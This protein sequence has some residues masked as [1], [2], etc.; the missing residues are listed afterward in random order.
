MAATIRKIPNIINHHY[1][2]YLK[3]FCKDMNIFFTGK[4]CF[5]FG[6]ENYGVGIGEDGGAGG[7]DGGCH[8]DDRDND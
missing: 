1:Y 4:I 2:Y 8:G 6:G 5:H 7:D 3:R